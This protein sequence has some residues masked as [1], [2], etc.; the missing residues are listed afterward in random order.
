[1]SSYET[2][3]DWIYLSSNWGISLSDSWNNYVMDAILVLYWFNLNDSEST[4]LYASYLMSWIT[5]TLLGWNYISLYIYILIDLCNGKT[6]GYWKYF[7]N[8]TSIV[9]IGLCRNIPEGSRYKSVLLWLCIADSGSLY[10]CTS[11]E[12]FPRTVLTWN[13]PCAW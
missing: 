3:F 9:L 2:N 5:L 13:G 11:Y 1:M 10:R 7:K 8:C 12:Q 6:K 4:C